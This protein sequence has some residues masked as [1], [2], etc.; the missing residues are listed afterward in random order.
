MDLF[1]NISTQYGVDIL[2]VPLLVPHCKLYWQFQ[3]YEDATFCVRTRVWS[4]DNVCG[5]YLS[6]QINWLKKDVPL[7]DLNRNGVSIPILVT[8]LCNYF[9]RVK[10][11][12]Y[13]KSYYF[14]WNYSSLGEYI[15]LHIRCTRSICFNFSFCSR[16]TEQSNEL[17]AFSNINQFCL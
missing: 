11:L 17:C 15:L 16:Q 8:L 1:R 12:I 4:C 10:P 5:V 6:F 14:L 7:L 13:Q 3:W 2:D 9:L